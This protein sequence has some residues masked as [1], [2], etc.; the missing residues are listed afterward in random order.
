M[1]RHIRMIPKTARAIKARSVATSRRRNRFRLAAA[2]L[3]AVGLCVAAAHQVLQSELQ[4]IGPPPLAMAEDLSTVVLDRNDALLRAFTTAQGRWRLPVTHTEVDPHY[5]QMLLEFE[6][7]RFYR[8]GGV[9]LLAV[10]RAG[11]QFLW[12]GRIVSGASTLTMQTA[13]LLEQRHERTAGGKMRQML[14]AIQLER[15]LTKQQILD[16]YLRLAPFGGNVE[17]VRAASLAYFGKEPRRLSL[18][19][20]ALLVALP[21]SP[22]AR[23]PDLEGNSAGVARRRVLQRARNAGLISQ[24]AFLRANQ[25]TL[26]TGR[27]AFP[28]LAPHLGEAMLE[29]DSARKVHNLT[30]DRRLQS[31]L[32][33]LAGRHARALGERLS[34][35]ILV[36][37]HTSGEVRAHVGSAGY[38]D[39]ERFGGIDMVHAVRSP[40]SALKP[41][42]YGLAFDM[43]IA[44]PETLIDDRPTRFGAYRPKNFDDTFRGTVTIRD[45]LARSLNIPAVKVLDQIGPGRFL[46]RLGKAGVGTTLPVDTEPSLAVALGGIGMTLRDLT[47]V[48]ATIARGGTPVALTH[49]RST[50]GSVQ[51]V[52]D[53]RKPQRLLSARAAHYLT[54]ILRDAPPPPNART[55]QIAF[56]TGTSYGYRDAWAVGFDGNHTIGVWV[57]RPDMT[58]TPGLL[59]RTAAAPILFDAFA[60]VSTRRV[61]FREAP[62]AVIKVAAGVDLPPPLRRFEKDLRLNIGGRYIDRPLAIAFPPDRSEVAIEPQ[63]AML[64]KADGGVLPLTWL[65]DGAPVG[66]SRDRRRMLWRP[67]GSGFAKVAVIDAKGRVDRVTVRLTDN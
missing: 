43:G 23:R 3:L 13:R 44:H 51:T 46:G 18:G 52:A 11:L 37:D 7:R 8:H 41:I 34:A 42:I 10:A 54:D 2:S 16:L 40:G 12:H 25:E 24:A 14:R 30:I 1:L 67:T 57:G 21:Q 33:R 45:A 38:L 17:G 64:L 31:A 4:R 9:D 6:D 22:E 32:Q 50:P 5:L 36:V 49:R 59:G 66:I 39:A 15:R 53:V 56:K 63:G 62:D 28:K 55:G 27:I 29:H 58:S 61:P 20:A 65:V 35:A 60:R 19:Q 47:A 26:P 48:F